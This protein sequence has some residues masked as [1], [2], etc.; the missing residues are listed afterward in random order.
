MGNS[1]IQSVIHCLY[2]NRVFPESKQITQNDTEIKS[3]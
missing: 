1:A 3:I 2:M